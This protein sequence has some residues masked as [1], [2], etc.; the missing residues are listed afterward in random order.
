MEEKIKELFLG[1]V[2]LYCDLRTKAG[3]PIDTEKFK[4]LIADKK[5][6]IDYES[7]GDG[8]F[9]VLKSDTLIKVNWKSFERYM[10]TGGIEKIKFFI[11]HELTHL[12]SKFA[13]QYKIIKKENHLDK[14]WNNQ[15]GDILSKEESDNDI[16]LSG[17][18]ATYGLV[19]IDEVLAQWTAE[20]LNDI[21]TGK[22]REKKKE[23]HSILGTEVEI[24]TD[25][26]DHDVYAPLEGYVEHFAKTLGFKSLKEFANSIITGKANLFELI[27]ENNITELAYIGIICQGIYQENGFEKCGLPDTDIPKAVRYLKRIK[28]RPTSPDVPTDPNDGDID[29]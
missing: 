3:M 1:A 15:Y 21:A 14:D 19:G 29:Y 9:N 7:D 10:K 13:E 12:S 2:E 17:W 6:D 5:V 28:D 24:E 18:D 20:E 27:N 4:K 26:T 8:I 22:K 11:L 25:F 16:F 23:K